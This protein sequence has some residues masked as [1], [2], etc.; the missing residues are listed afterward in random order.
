MPNIA[1]DTEIADEIGRLC[2]HIEGGLTL[3][4]IYETVDRIRDVADALRFPDPDESRTYI[5]DAWKGETGE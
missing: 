5:A 1:T 3:H 4:E 2:E